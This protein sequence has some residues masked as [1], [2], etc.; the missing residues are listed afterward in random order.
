M[1]ARQRENGQ[2]N[3]AIHGIAQQS[4]SVREPQ[5]KG[6]VCCHEITRFYA[7][8]QRQRLQSNED[9]LSL[10]TAAARQFSIRPP[11]AEEDPLREIA[12][13]CDPT[14][15]AVVRSW[16]R[17]RGAVDPRVHAVAQRPHR[18]RF[19]SGQGSP[20]TSLLGASR[21]PRR[22][23]VG[24]EPTTKDQRGRPVR[25]GAAA[26]TAKRRKISR[27][28]PRPP[29]ARREWRPLHPTVIFWA[30]SLLS[31][32]SLWV[33]ACPSRLAAWCSSCW[34][35][36]CSSAVAVASP[37]TENGSASAFFVS[38]SVGTHSPIRSAT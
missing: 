18:C 3:A 7:Q 13:Y 11:G 17:D 5:R 26:R 35:S 31:C 29:A 36:S 37:S 25:G 4:R 19:Q 30:S 28:P 8:R 16:R 38:D 27:A 14:A 23:V 32:S 9:A 20:R 22:N 6:R 33:T 10:K 34:R 12:C 15:A 24:S 21:G 2:G 1:R